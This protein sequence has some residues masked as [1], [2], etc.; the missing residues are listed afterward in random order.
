MAHF[1]LKSAVQKE[2]GR[3]SALL[4]ATLLGGMLVICLVCRSLP[5]RFANEECFR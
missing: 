3:A 4:V 5:V 2:T 1:D